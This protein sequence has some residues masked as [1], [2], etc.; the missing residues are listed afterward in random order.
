MARYHGIHESRF[1]GLCADFKVQHVN[2][3]SSFALYSERETPCGLYLE[4]GSL[5][6]SLLRGMCVTIYK[7]DPLMYNIC[8]IGR[9][10]AMS[11]EDRMRSS[12]SDENCI[13]SVISDQNCICSP[14]SDKIC[15][16][17]LMSGKN[18]V[19]S[20]T[21]DEICI[22]SPSWDDGCICSPAWDEYCICSPP[23]DENCICSRSL[24][25]ICKRRGEIC[26]CSP[27]RD[28]TYMKWNE[29]CECYPTWVEICECFHG[30]TCMMHCESDVLNFF[31]SLRDICEKYRHSRRWN[32]TSCKVYCT[33]SYRFHKRYKFWK[34][35][36]NGPSYLF[37]H[38]LYPCSMFL[39]ISKCDFLRCS[40]LRT[41]MR[42]HDYKVYWLERC[43]KYISISIM[44]GYCILTERRKRGRQKE[45]KKKK[46]ESMIM[47]SIG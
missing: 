35:R 29:T 32:I 34:F 47:K 26:E 6:I 40:F 14:M 25:I 41:L 46:A 12:V 42:K 8:M 28:E 7:I 17:S 9:C 15:T 3:M 11:Y 30:K 13:R 36:Y 31:L 33:S 24:N 20:P 2:H 21:W 44:Y 37:F 23:W 19:C 39:T 18:C 43:I 45:K 16:C 10:S 5:K 22:F 1:L 38:S 4:N 27:T